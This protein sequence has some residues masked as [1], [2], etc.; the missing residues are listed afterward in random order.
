[1]AL[2]LR[3]RFEQRLSSF[4][5]KPAPVSALPAERSSGLLG[6][7]APC[8]VAESE[9]PPLEIPENWT[10]DPA[11][12]EVLPVGIPDPLPPYRYRSARIAAR[13]GWF[14]VLARRAA[15]GDRE[16][17]RRA[18]EAME[19]WL[20]QDLPGQG[21]AWTHASDLAIRLI[22][23][24]AGL[25]WLREEAPASLREELAGSALWHLRHLELRRPTGPAE[26]LRQIL[27]DCGLIVGG[28]TFPG[29]PEARGW[30]SQGLSSL[31]WNLGESFFPDGVGRDRALDWQAQALWAVAIARAVTR[32]NGAAFPADAD[33]VFARGSRFLMDM[34]GE[35]GELPN[36]GEEPAPDLLQA[37]TPLAWSL[38]NL[39]LAW[40]LDRGEPAPGSEGDPRL[41]WLRGAVGGTPEV[42]SGKTWSVWSYREGGM[43]VA[44]LRVKN[45]PS[46]VV[47]DAGIPRGSP[48]SHPSPLGLTWQVGSTPVLA[49][50]GTGAGATDL[51]EAA[52]S[53][54]AHNLLVLLEH[55]PPQSAGL[56]RARVDGK[57]A[58]LE[59]WTGTPRQFR[60]VLLNQSRLL[61]T[62][63]VEV[64]A[65][66][67]LTWQLGPGWTLERTAEGWTGKNGSL[68]LIIQ[69]P[70]TL[71]WQV[72]EGQPAPE[73]RGWVWKEGEARAAPCL[74]GTGKME[75]GSKVLS[76]FEIR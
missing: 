74:V 14:A 16:A 13:H 62:D 46:R 15:L 41:G 72:V 59:G 23:W 34:A 9:F 69:V 53:P 43:A 7:L 3:Q 26:G 47:L 49:D 65:A 57:K 60:E 17:G 58:K 32:A 44:W 73:P 71:E 12:G 10:H 51:C 61:V 39:A 31:R 70:S 33:A 36:L 42:W 45:L 66:V 8:V 27:H 19:G 6:T 55:P 63:R 30:R 52:R 68:T 56:E 18:I 5:R 48:L 64:A 25:A 22:H 75:A 4:L 37:G 76:S 28:F 40:G 20:R 38:R 35:I 24:H 54:L 1:M 67:Q 50:P 11:T 21:I 29:L 2:G